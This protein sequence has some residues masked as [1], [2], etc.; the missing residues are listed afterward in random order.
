[1]KGAG[2]SFCQGSTATWSIHY[3]AIEPGTVVMVESMMATKKSRGLKVGRN[4][5]KCVKQGLT[6]AQPEC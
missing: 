1:M 6:A 2:V 3:A 5:S 4:E